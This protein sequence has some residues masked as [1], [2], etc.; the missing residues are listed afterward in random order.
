MASPNREQKFYNFA[1]IMKKK[2]LTIGLLALSL[3][4]GC[5]SKQ[6]GLGYRVTCTMD[7]KIHR[8]S[9]TLLVLE[10][11]YQQLRVCG[12]ACADQNTFSFTGQ[13][14]R[15]KVALIRWD[16]DS[17]RPF[18]FILEPGDI[19]ISIKPGTWDIKG[20]AGNLEYQQFVN[21][22]NRLMNERVATWQKYLKMS[23]DS[24][25]KR[26]DEVLLVRQDSLLNDSLQRQTVERIN[27]GDAVGL[28]I[29]ERYWQQLDAEHMRQLK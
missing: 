26:A 23:S 14:D 19:N 29:R 1:V 15:P 12:I 24:S 20:G 9:A 13:T 6:P 17:T 28:I 27:K 22:R 21:W 25:L 11:D 4:A 10:Q 8:D 16:N 2:I 5:D 18:Y 3:L 7:S